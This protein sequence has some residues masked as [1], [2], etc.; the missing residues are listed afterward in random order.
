MALL[1]K[2]SNALRICLCSAFPDSSPDPV[3]EAVL[4]VL[5][6]CSYTSHRFT[7]LASTAPLEFHV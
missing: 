2:T 4:A 5:Q 3:K 7:S 1:S 6:F